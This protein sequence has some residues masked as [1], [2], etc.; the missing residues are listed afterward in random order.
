MSISKVFTGD[1]QNIRRVMDVYLSPEKPTLVA[2]AESMGTT[3]HNIMAIV[4]EH[5]PPERRKVEKALRYSRSKM[6]V[7][8]PM[9]GKSGSQHHNYIGEI[10]DGDGYRMVKEGAVYVYVHRKV[11][12][13]LLGIQ[14]LPDS[15]EV[16]HIDEDKAN[17]SPDNLAVVTPSGHRH[18]H[19]KKSKFEKLPLWA[20]W[21]SGT[22]R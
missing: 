10:S 7:Q 14:D 11:M 15:V 8:N 13:D 1:P 6:G 18:L 3:L 17:N 22:L 2:I 16:H 5:T 4:K 20:Q 19:A 12:A 9:S 21:E